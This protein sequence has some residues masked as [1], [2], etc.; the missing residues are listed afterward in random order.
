DMK[1]MNMKGNYSVN[2]YKLLLQE[3]EASIRFFINNFISAVSEYR[4]NYKNGQTR[5]V[6]AHDMLNLLYDDDTGTAIGDLLLEKIKEEYS[7]EEFS[8]LSKAEQEKHADMTTILMQS[9]TASVLAIEQI[10]ALATDSGDSVW[11][12]R[13]DGTA[14]YDAML[15]NLIEAEGFTPSKAAMELS[16][17]Y[18]TDAKA[19][20]S[21][22]L[23]YRAYLMI[24]SGAEVSFAS[25]EED[26]LAFSKE[27][28]DDVLS[29]WYIAGTQYE[30]LK[31]VYDADGVSLLDIITDENNDLEGEDRYLLYSLA[32]ALTDG[33]R[34]CLELLT[35]Y[36]IVSMGISDDD[37]ISNTMSKLDIGAV[38]NGSISIYEGIDRAVFGENVAMTSDANSLQNSTGKNVS[39]N[40]F[41]DGISLSTKILYAALGVSFVATIGS[42]IAATVYSASA[43][44][45]LQAARDFEPLITKWMSLG[46]SDIAKDTAAVFKGQQAN[47]VSNFGRTTYWSGVWE[48]VSMGMACVTLI[49]LAVTLWFTLTDLIDYY[50]AQFTPIPLY[51]VHQGVNE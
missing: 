8:S 27:K 39:Q 16:S 51:I 43:A 37:T 29:S 36:Q 10:I 7:E 44:E 17:R 35:F 2:D 30:I 1:L 50:N 46:E 41:V 23:E 42:Y 31:S 25:S 26:I 14:S 5:A 13:Y 34:A 9:N 38:G 11:T 12:E 40:W 18:D 32:A 15:E 24:Y 47:A 21:K 45:H 49:L 33:Q 6:A 22:L 19:I 4:E 48:T 3:Q 20:A 28:G